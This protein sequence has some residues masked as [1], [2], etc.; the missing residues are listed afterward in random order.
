MAGSALLFGILLPGVL[1]PGRAAALEVFA[2]E[3]EWAALA[4]V[5]APDA[6]ITAATHAHQDPHHIEARPSLISAMRRADIAVC[7]GASLEAG[8]LPVLQQRA[9]NPAVQVGRPGMFFA[10]ESAALIDV[11]TKV[12]RSMG[13]VHA[14]GNPH[15]HLDPVRLKAVAVRLAERMSQV[16]PANAAGYRD[17]QARWAQ[18]WDETVA[19]W[20]A[21]AAPLAGKAVVAEHTSFAY[22]WEWLGIRQVGDLEPKPG[23]PPT[24]GHLQEVL[25]RARAERPIA[26]VQSLY[27]DPQAGRWLVDRISL[28]LLTLPSTVTTDGPTAELAGL[29]DHL[30]DQLLQAERKAGGR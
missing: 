17:R 20:R 9:A 27:Q 5:I 8:W 23:L 3:P 11:R 13:D 30:L 2:C 28:P 21:K 14:E 15:L 4:R 1:L 29:F 22:L 10:T 19:R 26:V 6:R 16:D 7:T 12:D 25:E 24:L 18:T